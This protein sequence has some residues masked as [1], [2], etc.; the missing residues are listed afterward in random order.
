MYIFIFICFMILSILPF[1]KIPARVYFIL[2]VA[3]LSF[4]A[5]I[6]DPIT[7]YNLHGEAGKLDAA[8][9]FE[10]M[11]LFYTYGI[12]DPQLE[13]LYSTAPLSKCYIWL[14]SYLPNHHFL[15]LIN[16]ML[17]F[18]ITGWIIYDFCQKHRYP[19]NIVIF[20]FFLACASA[21]HL[22]AFNNMRYMLAGVLFTL[23]W[24]LDIMRQHKWIRY[25][26]LIPILLHPGV[27][28]LL[29]LR[30]ATIFSMKK[31]VVIF[32]LMAIFLAFAFD[33]LFT[34][35]FNLLSDFLGIE[36]YLSALQDQS[37]SYFMGEVFTFPWRDKLV[38][39]GFW[40]ISL[41]TLLS[42][43]YFNKAAIKNSN[44]I[45]NIFL[46]GGLQVFACFLCIITDIGNGVFIDR[47]QPVSHLFIAL[48][49][50]MTLKSLE[51]KSDYGNYAVI[52]FSTWGLVVIR[53]CVLFYGPYMYYL[54]DAL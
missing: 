38:C 53:I 43:L 17:I 45:E 31:I 6:F 47:F 48:Y 27:I 32:P 50:V 20:G 9:I 37:L 3:L 11:D 1:F 7:F 41:W 40:I 29:I 30:V 51:E 14:A 19:N 2:F 18:G 16:N 13:W 5:Y 8:R 52:Y 54:Y 36:D 4:L 12:D 25:F 24:Y 28:L 26:Y 10:E 49:T 23:I 44:Q 15:P 34:L 21:Y 42:F 39:I 33:S 22:N 35:F 46:F